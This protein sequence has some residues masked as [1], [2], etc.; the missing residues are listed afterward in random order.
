MQWTGMRALPAVHKEYPDYCYMQTENMCGNSENDWST[1][2]NTWNA[3]VHCFNNGV[4]SYIYWN[5]VLNE[6]CKSW[7]DW[8]QNTLIIVDR[9][10]GQVRYTD[11]YYLMKHLSHF[12]QPGSRLLK[13]SDD[14]NTLAFRSHDGKVVVVAYNPEEQERPCSF[15]VGSKYIRV[16]LKGKSINTIVI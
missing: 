2:E 7:W 8:A 16:I 6:T 1:L 3:V 9:K 10:T 14:K 11:E 15:K 4:D 5:M 13:V 12:V